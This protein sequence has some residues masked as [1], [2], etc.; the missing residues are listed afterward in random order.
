MPSLEGLGVA[1]A[2]VDRR[3][4]RH[5]AP[6]DQRGRIRSP[7]RP[8]LLRPDTYPLAGRMDGTVRLNVDA[9]QNDSPVIGLSVTELRRLLDGAEVDLNGFLALAA[10]WLAQYLPGHRVPSEAGRPGRAVLHPLR[11]PMS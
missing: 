4:R 6:A 3:L 10:G 2:G 1:P 9:E 5:R 11:T 7:E 8:H